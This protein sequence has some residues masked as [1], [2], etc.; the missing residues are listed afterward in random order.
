MRV[1]KLHTLDACQLALAGPLYD[2]AATRAPRS[3]VQGMGSAGVA[4]G[5]DD[6]DGSL[7]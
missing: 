1:G 7:A 5:S 3:P 4:R 2:S 6:I